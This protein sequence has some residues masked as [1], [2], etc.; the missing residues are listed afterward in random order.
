ME[1]LKNAAMMTIDLVPKTKRTISLNEGNETNENGV[2]ETPPFLSMAVFA[3]VQY[4]KQ[5]RL[6]KTG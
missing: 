3:K 2:M 6:C 5:L 1:S 4:W